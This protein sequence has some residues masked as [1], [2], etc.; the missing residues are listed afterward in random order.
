MADRCKSE[1]SAWANLKDELSNLEA[2]TKGVNNLKDEMEAMCDELQQLDEALD[3]HL[4]AKEERDLVRWKSSVAQETSKI[5]A[6]RTKDFEKL[7]RSL[8]SEQDSRIR[9]KAAEEAKQ[10]REAELAA[11]AAA[12]EAKEEKEKEAKVKEE[13]EKREAKER[14]EKEK[15]EKAKADEAATKKEQETAPVAA[16]EDEAKAS[17]E[18]GKQGASAAPDAPQEKK[19]EAVEA[20]AEEQKE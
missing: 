4:K 12:A 19:V 18:D 20:A 9:K 7:E 5:Q 8:K 13:K 3:G 15:A 14:E 1:F 2:V 6:A 17:E 11:K 16:K 10:K